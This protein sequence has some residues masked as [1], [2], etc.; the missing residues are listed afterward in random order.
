MAPE[1]LKREE[2]MG[3]PVDI[4]SF[5]VLAFYVSEGTYPF[6]AQNVK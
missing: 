5:G 4:W 6:K 3:E 2:Y 1:V